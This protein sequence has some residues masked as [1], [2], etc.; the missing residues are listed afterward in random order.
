MEIVM[1]VDEGDIGFGVHSLVENKGQ[2]GAAF[3][4]LCI[5]ARTSSRVR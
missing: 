1:G 4:V 2:V 3:F 5:E